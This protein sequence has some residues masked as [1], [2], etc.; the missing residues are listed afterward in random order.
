M[1]LLV[2]VVH[3]NPYMKPPICYQE[4]IFRNRQTDSTILLFP[5]GRLWI[6]APSLQRNN[7]NGWTRK[8][9]AVYGFLITFT[10]QHIITSKIPY[11]LTLYRYSYNVSSYYSF[12]KHSQI[13]AFTTSLYL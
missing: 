5:T 3:H 13:V 12:P 7:M 2:R 1:A 11:L 10:V 4:Q 9:L 8:H 6:Y